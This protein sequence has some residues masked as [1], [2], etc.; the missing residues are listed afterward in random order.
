MAAEPKA[1]EEKS[2][3]EILT[4]IREIIAGEP[5]A[6]DGKGSMTEKPEKSKKDAKKEEVLDLTQ[7]VEDAA[8]QPAAPAPQ[9]A[10]APTGDVLQNIDAMLS[11]SPP[12]LPPPITMPPN[13][14][15]KTTPKEETV[16]MSDAPQNP[17]PTATSEQ[18]LSQQS[19]EAAA[20]SLRNLVSNI[21]QQ[22]IESPVTRSGNTIEDLVVET[23][24]PMLADWLNKNLPKIVERIVEKEVRK[25]MPR[26]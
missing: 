9:E 10:H 14:A 7:K 20:T 23:L 24:R 8:A 15:M 5:T 18:L 13:P 12:P 3:E 19:A 17:F 4:S 21:P 22:K 26:E 16:P 2:M 11:D 1:S 6:G 25:L